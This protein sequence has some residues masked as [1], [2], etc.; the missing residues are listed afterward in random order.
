MEKKIIIG[1]RGSKLALLYAYKAKEAIIQNTNLREE[2]VLIK[3]ISTKG[4]QIHDARLSD[5]GGKGL[6]SNNIEKELEENN[7]DIAVHALKDLPA[8]ETE[9]LLTDTFLE[10]NDPREI[11]ISN[12]KKKINEL[13][14]KSVVGTSSYRREYQIKKIKPDINCKLIRGNV[15]TRIKKLKEGIYDAII[16]SYAGIKFLDLEDEVSEIFEIEEIIPSAGQG[17]IALQC[18]QNDQRIISILKKVNH[19]ET[20]IRACV[21]KNILKVL[22]GDCETAIGAHSRIDGN[23]LVIEAELFSLDGSQRFYEKKITEVNKFRELGKEIGQ[24]LKIKSKNSYKK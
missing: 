18:R 4:D 5:V 17:I 22:D 19:E 14:S 16:L 13:N 1:S 11:L 21:E 7:I 20:Y 15:D 3:K 10:R 23:K 6:F 2:D 12:N 8:I 24:N 9:G